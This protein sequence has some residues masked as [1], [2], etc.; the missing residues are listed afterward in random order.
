MK[1]K[2]MILALSLIMV[3]Q[4]TLPSV[5]AASIDWGFLG[6]SSDTEE[7]QEGSTVPRDA[8]GAA[9][10]GIAEDGF[11]TPKEAVTAYIEGFCEMD[12]DKMI[13]ACA[14]ENY[15]ERFDLEKHVERMMAL[16]PATMVGNYLP[17]KDP[18]SFS[19]NCGRRETVLNNM[20]MFQYL[21][22]M[23]PGYAE[24]ETGSPTSLRDDLTAS[25][26]I[27]EKYGDG[28]VPEITFKGE[29]IPA[30]LMTE[31]YHKYQ[32]LKNQAAMAAVYGMEKKHSLCAVI[33]IDG[34]PS[35]LFLDA[36]RYDG[37]WYVTDS[38]MLAMIMGL[39]TYT[40]GLINT[41]YDSYETA[42]LRAG[43]PLLLANSALMSAAEHLDET[44]LNMDLQLLAMAGQ[45]DREAGE[46]M[47]ETT[48]KSALT[49]EELELL[50]NFSENGL[51]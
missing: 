1:K 25:A 19:I 15:V 35:L 44:I 14:V 48:I 8:A 7:V 38:S 40:G 26:L 6:S 17:Y 31:H 34:C 18:M 5:N 21:N 32:N 13:S 27:S 10:E 50:T 12:Y 22:V 30:D 47:V 51:F 4:M 16:M 3:F 11:A 24:T 23:I 28:R 20:I 46:N 42:D 36:G 43:I 45:V 41:K 39:S 9:E 49:P 37:R 33:Y 2:I 29:F